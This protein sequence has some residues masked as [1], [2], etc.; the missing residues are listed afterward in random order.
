MKERK[1]VLV[2]KGRRTQRV[3]A[4]IRGTRA[5]PR[6]AVFRSNRSIYAQLIDD[7]AGK[8]LVAASE[9][10]LRGKEGK[11]SKSAHAMLVGELLAKKAKE[12][13]VYEAVFDRRW[14]T[15]HGRIKS[16][17]DGARKGGLKI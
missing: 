3:R 16:L 9:K 8:T 5:R 4:K 10:E 17:A 13:G 1:R 6:L 15:Y 7:A 14:Y 12:Q 2:L 11:K